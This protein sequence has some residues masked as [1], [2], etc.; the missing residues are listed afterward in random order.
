M[1]YTFSLLPNIETKINNHFNLT[2]KNTRIG[3][4][5][6]FLIEKEIKIK[7]SLI[8]SP[9]YQTCS[10]RN[11]NVGMNEFH[12][13]IK[14]TLRYSSRTWEGPLC[15][16]DSNITRILISYNS[17]HAILGMFLNK[18][19]IWRHIASGMFLRMLLAHPPQKRVHLKMSSFL[20]FFLFCYMLKNPPQTILIL[21]S[22]AKDGGENTRRK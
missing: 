3:I 12:G 20:M 11:E 1:S 15:A 14:F 5:Q 21:E 2:I 7:I 16:P 6:C 4:T 10:Q 18:P 17:Q 22:H 9:I 8:P 13:S 19:L